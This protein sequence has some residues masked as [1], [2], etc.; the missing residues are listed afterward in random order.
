M[1]IRQCR[2]VVIFLSLL[3]L[4]AAIRCGDE[5]KV[6]GQNN[7][8]VPGTIMADHT[9]C[10]DFNLI[11][12]SVIEQVKSDYR[13]WYGHTSHGSQIVTGMWMLRD[14][15]SVYDYNNGPGTLYLEEYGSDLGSDGEP[16]GIK[17]DFASPPESK[18]CRTSPW[19]VGNVNISFQEIL[20]GHLL[21]DTWK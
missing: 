6:V 18:V 7:Q 16:I 19:F 9:I 20:H 15:S 17:V 12:S 3:V 8:K 5:D 10:R 1:G 13:I 4:T 14:S 11:P 2:G 21:R